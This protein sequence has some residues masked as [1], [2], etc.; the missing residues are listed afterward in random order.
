MN[1]RRCVAAAVLCVTFVACV[2]AAESSYRAFWAD[3]FHEGFRSPAEVD[4]MLADL[5]SAK[6]NAI[7]VETRHRGAVYYVKSSEPQW[8]DAAYPA[9]FDAMQYTIDKAREHGIEVHFWSPVTPVWTTAQPPADPRHVWNR[10]GPNAKGDEMWMTV[11]AAGRISTS[12]DLGHPGAARYTADVFIDALRNYDLD[13]I[14][15]DYIRY[16]ED[17]RYGWNPVTVRRFNRLHAR[18][19]RPADGDPAWADFRR[20]QV[21][22]FVRQVYLRAYEIKASAKVTAALITWG[23]G[24]R[25]DAE[26]R[27]KDAYARVFQDWPRWLQ[28]GIIDYGMPMNYFRNSQYSGY[29]DRWLEFE[30][31]N[32]FGRGILPGLGIYLNSIAETMS[33]VE[34]VFAPSSG[35]KTAPGVAFYSYAVTNNSV[36]PP[37]ATFYRTIAGYFKEDARPPA[38]PWKTN[39]AVGHILGTLTVDGGPSHLSDGIEVAIQSDTD[40]NFIRRT[41]TDGTGFFGALDF[42]P[43]TYYVRLSRAGRELFRTAPASLAAGSALRFDVFLKEADF[44]ATAPQIVAS[45]K[46]AAAPGELVA[47]DVARLEPQV[48]VA[49]SVPLPR[50]LSGVQVLVN[51]T[52][53]PLSYVAPGRAEFQ[54]PLAATGAWRVAVRYGGL[55]SAEFE[56][57]FV[58][59]NPVLT[60]VRKTA[61]GLEVFATGLGVTN[62]VPAPG[63]GGSATAPYHTVAGVVTASVDNVPVKVLWAGLEPYQPYRYQINLESAFETGELLISVNGVAARPFRF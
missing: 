42:A 56:I 22:D 7:F 32:Q 43:D 40:P 61:W 9:G 2:P 53:A 13:G 51:D 24:P 35:N 17:D 44:A 19:G 3:A 62:P 1:L 8:V 41:V 10:H 11:N 27:T 50:S 37:N 4:R 34:R 49:S 48:A 36:P 23:D 31:A 6:A 15:L 52:A 21:T 46:E 16:P 29:L 26:F 47:L 18:D 59:A 12:L 33:Q 25:S 30:K 5:V 63:A 45:D 20:K 55:D 54:M 28:E 38:M 57:P 60:G 14:H 39:P 58:V